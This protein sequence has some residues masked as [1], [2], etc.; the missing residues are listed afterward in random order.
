MKRAVGWPRKDIDMAFEFGSMSTI[1]TSVSWFT[2]RWH[3]VRCTG[4]G[5]EDLAGEAHLAEAVTNVR[6]AELGDLLL[7]LVA[8]DLLEEQVVDL[9]CV[10]RWTFGFLRERVVEGFVIS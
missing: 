10:L 1:F 6:S 3:S 8:A 9:L 4:C 2:E 5:R 7:A